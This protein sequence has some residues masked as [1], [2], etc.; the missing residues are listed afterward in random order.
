[1]SAA[2][3][4]PCLLIDADHYAHLLPGIGSSAGELLAERYP[5]WLLALAGRI[6]A[7]RGV[8]VF[9]LARGF[10]GVVAINRGQGEATLTVLEAWLRRRRTVVLLE[11]I[12]RPLPGV[13]WRAALMRIWR[14]VVRG[15]SLRRSLRAGHV[16]TEWE[17][18]E[19]TRLY[20]LP[21]GCLQFVPW[22]W[23]MDRS[24]AD[25]PTERA[26]ASLVS[27]GYAH[28]DWPTLFAAA[29]G[30]GWS[31]TV[32]C[33]PA[34][35]DLV[36]DLNGDGRARVL[37]DIPR[38]QH[39]EL[40]RTAALYVMCLSEAGGSTGQVRLMQA[41]E[42]ATP[43]VATDVR[44]LAGY[45]V[46]GETAVVVPPD[47]PERLGRAVDDLLADERRRRA[48]AAAAYRR[49]QMWP[50][51]AYVDAIGRLIRGDEPPVPPS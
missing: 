37:C 27:S 29:R 15:P 8:L 17:R 46:P 34:D 30:R 31:L 14:T 44:G 16:L 19:L 20:R 50:Y 39:F 7:L 43:V 36:T 33:G 25:A 40:V 38:E 12:A 9:R 1:M 18:E 32:V 3:R 51:A 23:R 4:D 6:G 47:S 26:G 21:P 24:D 41:N 13:W 42:A 49:S 35:L 45:L 48:V 5:R 28:C 2:P 10:E 11:L 22:P